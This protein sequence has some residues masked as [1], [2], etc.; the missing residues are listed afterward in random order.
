MSGKSIFEWHDFAAHDPKRFRAEVTLYCKSGYANVCAL[1]AD[2]K[3]AHD[4]STHHEC[5][6]CGAAFPTKQQCALHQFKAHNIKRSI[7]DRVDGTYCSVCLVQF[8]TR[9]RLV[10]HLSEK[11]EACRMSYIARKPVLD[12]AV[13]AELEAEQLAIFKANSRMGQRRAYADRPCSRLYG[14]LQC[15]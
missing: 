2:D 13:V 1:W 6:L 11:S 8:W 15:A 5:P 7:R 12:A 14:P 9:E 4:L 3:I 10:C